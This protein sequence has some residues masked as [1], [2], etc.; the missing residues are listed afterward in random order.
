MRDGVGGKA[1]AV[2]E[3]IRA[4][5]GV[6]HRPGADGAVEVL[7]VHRP[8]YDDWTL[9]KGK[10]EDGESY[11][12]AAVRE[13]EEETSLRCRLGRPL[14]T[15]AYESDGRPKEVRYWE[16]L[17]IDPGEG[18]AQHEVDD[19]RWLPIADA[20]AA[21]SYDRDRVVL[22]AFAAGARS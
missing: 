10:L 12:G 11:E 21:L 19:L 14:P 6:V 16:M 13:V 4:A 1:A 7:L 15:T 2:A 18:R 22:D 20:R 9:P 8:K 3:L 5:G 17:P